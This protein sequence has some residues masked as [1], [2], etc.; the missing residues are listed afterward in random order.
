MHLIV[1]APWKHW[2]LLVIGFLI[3]PFPLLGQNPELAPSDLA[4]SKLFAAKHRLVAH[5]SYETPLKE[6]VKFQYERCPGLVRII[7][8][9]KGEYARSKGQV[10]L[11]SSDWGQS[12]DPAEDSMGRLLDFYAELAEIPWAE[13]THQDKGQGDEVW[14]LKNH[15]EAN[16]VERF[17]YEETRQRPK[18]GKLYP[19]F[20]FAKHRNDTEGRLLLEH[21][22][23][24]VRSNA[25]LIPVEIQFGYT[26]PPPVSTADL[27]SYEVWI[28]GEVFTQEDKL[29]FRTDKPVQGNATDNVV[30][31]GVT[32]EAA[33]V[34]PSIY[35]RAAEKHAKLRLYGVLMP[36][37]G[38][39]A[40]GSPSVQFIT[41]KV[42]SPDDPDELPENQK[43]PIHEG[44]KVKGNTVYPESN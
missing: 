18:P 37:D 27:S 4:Y 10:W 23:A 3:S 19:L 21:F 38:N 39:A 34:L 31:L 44:D 8:G 36:V 15:S 7:T 22:S 17:T 43:M 28:T 16:G 11:R 13:T 12:G 2:C 24:N 40:K 9:D 14:K 33:G 1:S 6:S 35:A 29:L 30:L 20:T 42:H 32:R 26:A 41:W 5:V 25:D